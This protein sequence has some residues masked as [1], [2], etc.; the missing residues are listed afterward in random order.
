MAVNAPGMHLREGISLI[1]L[2]QMFPDDKAA[3]A[4]FIH[5]R[6]PDGIACPHCVNVNEKA[7]H[8]TMPFRCR[9][10][11]KYFS[12]KTDTIMARSK[13]GYQI[14]VIA[15][16]LYTTHLKGVSSMKLHRDLHIT[17]RTAW[18]LLHRIRHAMSAEEQS[19]FDGPVE[20][21]ET[22]VGG[23]E[24]N[25]H[26]R[27][28]LRVG[29]GTAGKIPVAGVKNRDTKQVQA[30]VV[31]EVDEEAMQ[32]FISERVEEGATVYTDGSH[33]Y[34][35]LAMDGYEHEAVIHSR[36][37]YVRGDAHT[38]GIEAFWSMIKR[39]IMGVYHKVSRKHLGKYVAEFVAKQNLRAVDTIEQMKVVVQRFEGQRLRYCELVA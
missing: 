4:W 31:D 39:A 37:E 8:P 34:H 6:W 25:K 32:A 17:Q 19:F 5:T 33:V 20:V 15:I 27:D 21:D 22:Y 23:K 35:G 13:L 26:A 14:W 16:Y 2:F 7:T 1:R 24:G 38:N 18:F 10:C 30:M 3:K 9:E 12:P 28:K 36:G 29:R 11:V